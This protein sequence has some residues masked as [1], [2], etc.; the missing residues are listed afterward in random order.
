L[1]ADWND[2]VVFAQ[3]YVDLKVEGDA[4]LAFDRDKAGRLTIQDAEVVE[5]REVTVTNDEPE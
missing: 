2:H 4:V 1:V 3:A 5:I